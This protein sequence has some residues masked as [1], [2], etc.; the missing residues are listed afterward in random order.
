MNDR[1][2]LATSV[3]AAKDTTGYVLWKP[4]ALDLADAVIALEA[5]VSELTG[6]IA[7]WT[8]LDAQARITALE[9]AL[10]RISDRHMNDTHASLDWEIAEEALAALAEGDANAG[11]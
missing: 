1:E 4:W 8:P 7:A 11:D 6:V 2:H 9:T 3:L 5:R 10:R